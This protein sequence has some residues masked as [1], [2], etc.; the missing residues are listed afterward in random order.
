MAK[1]K[2]RPSPGGATA[3]KRAD[4]ETDLVAASAKTV[5]T[6]LC[7]RVKTLALHASG[8]LKRAIDTLYELKPWWQ[9]GNSPF[10]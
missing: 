2:K 4:L 9:A 7:A 3:I 10:V 5:T 1:V 6:A 8:A